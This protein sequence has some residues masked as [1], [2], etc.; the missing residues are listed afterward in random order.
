MIRREVISRAVVRSIRRGEQ[1]MVI[2]AGRIFRC[3]HT[4]VVVKRDGVMVFAC[5]A[6]GYRTEELPLR[7]KRSAPQVVSF[8]AAMTG[9]RISE[10]VT[11]TG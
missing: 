3:T 11:R 6:C 8:P 7:T 4:Y 10:T 1:E 2:E 9:A 5:M